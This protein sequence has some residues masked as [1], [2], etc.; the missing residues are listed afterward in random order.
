MEEESVSNRDKLDPERYSI[1]TVSV[2]AVEG[3]VC[4]FI[5]VVVVVFVCLLVRIL[6]FSTYILYTYIRM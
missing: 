1:C 6:F 3:K 4:L 5:V 2:V